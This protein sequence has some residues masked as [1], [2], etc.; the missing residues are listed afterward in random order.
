MAEPSTGSTLISF[1]DLFNTIGIG[2][3]ADN[4]ITSALASIFGVGGVFPIFSTNILF[5]LMTWFIG[6]YIVHL[7]V[8]F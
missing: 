3:V 8:D 7:A 2:F 4:I 1:S 5:E 6:V